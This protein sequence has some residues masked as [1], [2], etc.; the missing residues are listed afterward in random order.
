LQNRFDAMVYREIVPAIRADCRSDDIGIIT[1]GASIGAFN[2]VAALCRHPDVFPIALGMSGTYDLE[3]FL[4]GGP[5]TEEL[6]L[7]LAAALSAGPGRGQRTAAPAAAALRRT[8][9][10]PGPLGR[11]ERMLAAG[12]GAGFQGRAQPGRSLGGGMGS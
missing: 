3:R 7:L 9:L 8:G 12:R 1:A 5:F 6:Y 10:R 2:A 4:H 11:S